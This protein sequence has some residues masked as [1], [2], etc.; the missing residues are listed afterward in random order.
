[1]QYIGRQNKGISVPQY[2]VC[3]LQVMNQ[4]SF[5]HKIDLVIVVGVGTQRILGAGD[6]GN[7]KILRGVFIVG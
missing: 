3:I 7:I 4:R 6:T 2:T 1:M 5:F